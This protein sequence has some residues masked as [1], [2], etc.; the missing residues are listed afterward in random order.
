MN[1]KDDKLEKY[2]N[3][4]EEKIEKLEIDEQPVEIELEG[5]LDFKGDTTIQQSQGLI[6]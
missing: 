6:V 3:K 1:N 2:L 4:N 5:T